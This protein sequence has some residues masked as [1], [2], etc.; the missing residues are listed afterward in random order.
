[1]WAK[2]ISVCFS[3]CFVAIITIKNG[4]L[5]GRLFGGWFFFSLVIFTS[6]A[7][8]I[9][10]GWLISHLFASIRVNGQTNR[11]KIGNTNDFFFYNRQCGSFKSLGTC[12]KIEVNAPT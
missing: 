4:R 2:I 7:A 1:M 9:V 3:L 5:L 11:E 8:D 12:R 6:I 10:D